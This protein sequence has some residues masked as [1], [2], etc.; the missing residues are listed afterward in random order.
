MVHS[1]VE[2]AKLNGTPFDLLIYH[3][4]QGADHSSVGER[5][6]IR[7]RYFHGT[8]LLVVTPNVPDQTVELTILRAGNNLSF[9]FSELRIY[10]ATSTEE[11]VEQINNI[12][13]PK[14]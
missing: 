7:N 8:P 6:K 3:V 10:F 12:L 1:D 13:Y 2:M 14:K 11:M 9:F 4:P 5:H